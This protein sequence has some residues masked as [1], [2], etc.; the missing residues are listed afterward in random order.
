M[1]RNDVILLSLSKFTVTHTDI[2]YCNDGFH[3]QKK[4]KNLGA[5]IKYAKKLQDKEEPEYGIFLS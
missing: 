5:A 1:S 4:F 2:E 3:S